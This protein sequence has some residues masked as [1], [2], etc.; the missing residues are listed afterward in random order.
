MS[1][2]VHPKNTNDESDMLQYS[3]TKSE[4]IIFGVFF[5]FT[6]V[7]YYNVIVEKTIGDIF[8]HETCFYM[9]LLIHR[10]ECDGMECK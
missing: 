7:D 8:P 6:A 9:W 1:K 10:D 2:Q 5:S 4:K 3:I